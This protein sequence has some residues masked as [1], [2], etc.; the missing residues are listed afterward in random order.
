MAKKPLGSIVF[1]LLLLGV[2]GTLIAVGTEA[3]IGAG[4]FAI[5]AAAIVWWGAAPR[6]Q[7]MA[8]GVRYAGCGGTTFC[9]AGSAAR[10]S[11]HRL[12]LAKSPVG[13]ANGWL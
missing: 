6:K 5:L 8:A 7:V 1:S 9:Q 10:L 13:S 3:M 12:T 11:Y 4:A 2:G